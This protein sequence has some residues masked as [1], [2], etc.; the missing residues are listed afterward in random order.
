MATNSSRPIAEAV[1]LLFPGVKLS[2]HT[3]F[4]NGITTMVNSSWF[5]AVKVPTKEGHQR[6]RILIP[7]EKMTLFWNCTL[8]HGL[9]PSSRTIGQ[10]VGF[11]DKRQHFADWAHDLLV[12]RQTVAA[13]GLLTPE[14]PAFLEGLRSAQLD[15]ERLPNPFSILPQLAL[16]GK[17][18]LLQAQLVQFSVL[19]QGDSMMKAYFDGDLAE[20]ARLA[21]AM[22]AECSELI[23]YKLMILNEFEQRQ[24]FS[25]AFEEML[26]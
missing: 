15:S 12:G 18:G 24:R 7:A 21:E 13:V 5:G 26:E 19:S 10:V 11:S 20:A 6:D 9:V 25:R 3:E 8:I 2:K 22:S 14:L 17:T 23:P 4:K 1:A 16:G